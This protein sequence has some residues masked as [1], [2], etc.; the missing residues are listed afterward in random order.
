MDLIPYLFAPLILFFPTH[1]HLLLYYLSSEN[2]TGGMGTGVWVLEY[3]YWSIG[4]GVWVLEYRYWSMGTEYR[5][6]SMGTGV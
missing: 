2:G 1:T 5:Y 3:G 6:W 4:T